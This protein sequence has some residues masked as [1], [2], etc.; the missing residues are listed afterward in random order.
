MKVYQNNNAKLNI[1]VYC[2]RFRQNWKKSHASGYEVGVG[3]HA[4]R[5]WGREDKCKYVP[6]MARTYLVNFLAMSGG[7]RMWMRFLG[8]C[9]YGSPLHLS[10]SNLTSLVI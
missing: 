9:G 6:V 7:T 4:T 3:T 2:I 10:P 1:E 8:G 5:E